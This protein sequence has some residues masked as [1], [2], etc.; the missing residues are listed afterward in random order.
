MSADLTSEAT[1]L[2]RQAQAGD[3]AAFGRLVERVYDEMRAEARRL[4]SRERPDHTLEPT[5]LLNEGLLRMLG[6]EAGV[7][8]ADRA[9]FFA[10]VSRCMERVLIDHARQKNAVKRGEGMR[11]LP[12]DVK[13]DQ[14]DHRL[15]TSPELHAAL[16]ELRELSPEQHEVIHLRYF[17]GYTVEEVAGLRGVSISKVEADFRHAR[18]F[19]HARLTDGEQT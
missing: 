6:D 7:R 18:A 19:L 8:V 15:E 5:A 14:I 17:G 9:Y 2:L 1:E 3:R 16:D 11:P 12:L 4:M 10:A 13:F